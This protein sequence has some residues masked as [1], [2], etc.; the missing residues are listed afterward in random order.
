MIDIEYS[1]NTGR[2]IAQELLS[3]PYLYF[4]TLTPS[5]I[6]DG[7][8]GVYAIF[9]EKSGEVLYVGRTKNL[10][11]RLYT[12]HL[13][14]PKTNARLKKY[15]VEDASEENITSMDDAKQYL[16]KYCYAKY[17]GGRYGSE[18]KDRRV[19]KLF[20]GCTVHSRRTLTRG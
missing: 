14:G 8:A 20:T 1:L 6:P 17:I 10:R 5:D 9:D 4:G 12:N 13:H 16:K 19:I 15:L 7:I 11:R 18:G 3:A 2:A